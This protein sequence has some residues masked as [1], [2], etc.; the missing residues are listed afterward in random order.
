MGKINKGQSS[1]VFPHE[2]ELIEQFYKVYNSYSDTDVSSQIK[3]LKY[4]FNYIKKCYEKG[5]N[6]EEIE[7]EIENYIDNLVEK[8]EDPTLNS[9]YRLRTLEYILKE[10][11]DI[12]PH[13]KNIIER[14]KSNPENKAALGNCDFDYSADIN[15]NIELAICDILEFIANDMEETT[16]K[17]YEQICNKIRIHTLSEKD[18]PDLIKYFERALNHLVIG[19]KNSW[20]KL[21]KEDSNLVYK[22]ILANLDNIVEVV[23]SEDMDLMTLGT[24]AEMTTDK[25]MSIEDVI[26]LAKNSKVPLSANTVG[27]KAPRKVMVKK[28]VFLENPFIGKDKINNILIHANDLFA[29]ADSDAVNK[30]YYFLIEAKTN[31][32]LKETLI[33]SFSSLKYGSNSLKLR[34]FLR[35]RICTLIDFFEETGELEEFNNLNNER[36]N[37]IGLDGLSIDIKSLKNRFDVKNLSDCASTEMLTAMSAFYTNRLSKVQSKYNIAEF[38]FNQDGIVRKVCENPNLKFEDLGYTEESVRESM[39]KFKLIEGLMTQRFVRDFSDEEFAKIGSEEGIDLDDRLEDS[40]KKLSDYSRAYKKNFG[41]NFSNDLYSVYKKYMTERKIYS[42]KD[43]AIFTLIYTTVIDR[44]NNVVNWGY[45]KED[46]E[47]T[48]FSDHRVLLG[49][50]VKGL[51]MPISVHIDRIKLQKFMRDLTGKE[52]IPVYE[53]K[54]D[55]YVLPAKHYYKPKLLSTL[56]LYPINKIQ[57]AFINKGTKKILKHLAWIQRPSK[58]PDG[59]KNEP[60]S[61]VY[62]FESGKII[63]KKSQNTEDPDASNR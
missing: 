9:F 18:I 10:K 60:G 61:R 46:E 59:I 30:L 26:E 55:M 6:V 57:R 38:I 31:K 28:K 42:L 39:A 4:M 47:S 36:L 35:K 54:D 23:R 5:M 37:S 22:T 8:I 25:K 58:R 49:F 63:R 32:S 53:G 11:I 52:Q 1:R 20:D 51:N 24:A 15:Q 21:L 27:G 33:K 14:Q 44:E 17:R 29:T 48:S 13:L 16:D 62:D 41:G 40:L 19:R 2:S 45:I 43:Y 7:S 34:P 50:D 56:V 3:A 12:T